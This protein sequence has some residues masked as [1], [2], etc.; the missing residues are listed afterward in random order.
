MALGPLTNLARLHLRYPEALLQTANLVVMGGAVNVPGNV[1][2]YAEFNFYSDPQAAKIVLSSHVPMTIVDLGACRRVRISRQEAGRLK[3]RSSLGRLAVQL[4]LNWF[5]RQP[6]REW[7][8]FYDPLALAVALDPKVVTTYQTSLTVVTE[9]QDRLGASRT[10]GAGSPVS[11]IRQVDEHR[12][13]RLLHDLMELDG[14]E[15]PGH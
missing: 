3:A 6:Q 11:L 9:D 4:I 5:R 8:E 14:L 10:T 1:T 2:P 7:F 12:F 15:Y 13:F